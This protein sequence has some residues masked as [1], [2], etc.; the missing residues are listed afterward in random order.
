[1]AR[2][3]E[4]AVSWTDDKYWQAW[5]KWDEVIEWEDEEKSSST[6]LPHNQASSSNG[7]LDAGMAEA[8]QE[9]LQLYYRNKKKKSR[10]TKNQTPAAEERRGEVGL[11]EPKEEA[12]GDMKLHQVEGGK[13]NIK[14]TDEKN[15][16]IGDID[17]E[18]G[19]RELQEFL[20]GDAHFDIVGLE[21]GNVIVEVIEDEGLETELSVEV[22]EVEVVNCDGFPMNDVAMEICDM[23][24][25]KVLL[26]QDNLHVNKA[27]KVKVAAIGG[28]VVEVPLKTSRT[29][30][31]KKKRRQS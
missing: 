13:I 14:L 2:R 18:I 22:T 26:K 10:K 30:R 20:K 7:G 29:C 24:M 9:S 11:S 5:D 3:M 23:Q 12:E 1:M 25:E 16:N 4:K 8:E 28:N 21:I 19:L 6:T 17:I 31:R 15:V 27:G